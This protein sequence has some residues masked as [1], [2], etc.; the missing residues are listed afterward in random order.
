VSRIDDESLLEG[1][2][3]RLITRELESRLAAQPRLVGSGRVD[4]ADAPDVLARHLRDVALR[5]LRDERTPERR[6][7]VLTRDVG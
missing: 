1:L 3:E 6:L 7:A 4:D 2:Y 5:A